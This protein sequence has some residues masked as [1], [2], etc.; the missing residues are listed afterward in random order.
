[1]V[2]YMVTPVGAAAGDC[3]WGLLDFAE[4]V[5]LFVWPVMGAETSPLL[6]LV[7][8]WMLDRLLSLFMELRRMKYF[9]AWLATCVGVL[10][11]TKFREM[12]LQSPFP[13]LSNP[14][15]NNLFFEHTS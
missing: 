13:Y 5:E 15:R 8:S 4:E 11:T 7:M 14:R 9:W 10:V 3:G 1:M 2:G 6:T 12:L